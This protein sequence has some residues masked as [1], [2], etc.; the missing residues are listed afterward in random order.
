M[1]DAAS[2]EFTGESTRRSTCGE[3]LADS[4]SVELT[5]A[6][7][8][9][10]TRPELGIT[11]SLYQVMASLCF[12]PMWRATFLRVFCLY[13]HWGQKKVVDSLSSGAGAARTRG[14]ICLM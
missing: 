5:T 6:T 14:K 2:A 11:P 10:D 8:E 12:I 7:A 13:G 3:D 1:L 4:S 9:D